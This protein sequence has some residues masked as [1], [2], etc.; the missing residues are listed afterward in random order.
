MP[1]SNDAALGALAAKHQGLLTSQIVERA[2]LSRM[3]LSRAV[4][5]GLFLPVEPTVY[6]VVGS[7]M[8]LEQRALAGALRAG[9]A[10]SHT[11][12]AALH[13][14]LD[15]DGVI[16]VV[17]PASRRFS[18]GRARIHRSRFLPDSHVDEVCGV[19][20]T[21][22]ERTLAD[23]GKVADQPTVDRVVARA[24]KRRA[25]TVDRLDR[26]AREYGGQGRDGAA[27]IRRVLDARRGLTGPTESELEEFGPALFR[28]ADLPDPVAQFEVTVEGVRYRLDFA[29][30]EIK[31]AVEMDGFEV[32]GTVEV[33]DG[34]R[35]RDLALEAAGWKVV[36]LG[37]T[38]VHRLRAT[39]VRRLRSI[40]RRRSSP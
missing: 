14:L 18:G 16:H 40:Y 35:V 2:G 24:L 29:W 22:V 13:G 11:T 8:T 4:A 30:P 39:T 28:D 17:T 27:A 19:P 33:F 15:H 37:S 9:G 36:H 10:A 38:Q 6:A 1:A 31:F 3:T 20:T 23:L 26:L 34:D 32:H 21:T 5:K 25:T 12:A 7:P